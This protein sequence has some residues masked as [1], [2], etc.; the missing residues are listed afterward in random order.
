[1]GLLGLRIAIKHLRMRLGKLFQV[2][3]VGALIFSP[4]MAQEAS[5]VHEEAL[6]VLRG[7]TNRPPTTATST[8]SAPPANE[9]RAEREARMRAEAQQRVA[10][11]ERQQAERRRQFEEYVKERERL[12]QERQSAGQPGTVHNQALEVLRKSDTTTP[13]PAPATTT[14]APATRSTPTPAATPSPST[15]PKSS[16]PQSSNEDVQQRA[17]EVVRTE[18]EQ[19]APATANVAAAP[20][21]ALAQSSADVHQKALEV[22]RQ[23][24]QSAPATTA[25][26]PAPAPAAPA[27]PP[28]A[29]PTTSA[30][31]N[32]TPPADRKP[33]PE[34]QRR[35]DEMQ[36]ELQ[37][38]QQ[39][40][41]AA[42]APQ[43]DDAY[44]RELEQRALQM[45]QERP[46]STAAK[47]PAPSSAPTAAATPALDTQTREMIRRQDQ[48]AARQPAPVA[49]PSAASTTA[50][51]DPAAEARA[52]E[53]LRQQQQAVAT[54]SPELQP[55]GRPATPAPAPRTTPPPASPAPIATAAAAAPAGGSEVQYS[56]ELED[57][58]R[59]SLLQ[60]AQADQPGVSSA[61]SAPTVD[62]LTTPLQA[63]PKTDQLHNRALEA[64]VQV[65][66]AEGGQTRPRNKQE[67]LRALTELYRADKMT[68]ADYHQR[69]AQILAEQN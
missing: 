39:Q 23:Q 30:P 65:E 41:G 26:S 28:P 31:R 2:S 25:P 5:K 69:R 17:L 57:R 3:F 21:G 35:L 18:R 9:T 66:P 68:P 49:Q 36:R 12:R 19:T 44:K 7:E 42:S 24:S 64:L 60:R 15:A 62:P 32:T 48:Q 16:K 61:A 43:V 40:R 27:T 1:M 33:S 37:V 11:R 34:L 4:L 54:P 58:A 59:Q 14:P 20:S 63:D 29:A 50:T 6:K 51:L 56:R 47:A 13:S 10:E 67:R 53:I 45:M 55:A 38:E 8:P 52:R 46:A 22:L